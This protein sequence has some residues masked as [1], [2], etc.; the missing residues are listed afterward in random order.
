MRGEFVDLGGHRFYYFAAGTRGDG[1]PVVL[2]HGFPTSSRLWH[3]VIRDF[4]SGHRLVVCD[5]PGYGRS[6]PGPL[7]LGCGALADA[8]LKLLDDLR[9][10]RAAL[11]GHGLGGGVAQAVA[12]A[13]RDRVSH[14]ALIDSAA[15]GAAPRA[16]ARFARRALPLA[17][18]LPPGLLAGLVQGSAIRGFADPERSRLT[19]D[20]CLQ[21]FTT[22]MG[23]DVL[24]RHLR[25]LMQDE[26]ADL[27]PRLASLGIP[28]ALAWGRDDRFYPASLGQ[29]LA[30]AVPG[31]TLELIDGAGHFTPE[32][33][34]DRVRA[35]ITSL[36]AR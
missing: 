8:V 24:A 5:L 36:L 22:P 31:A 34:P 27:T 14:L 19:L 26:T 23:R 21:P 6:E 13:R 29:R 20:T 11:V 3:S 1:V 30:A 4:P 28:V 10:E 17:R 7:G 16:L 33:A 18:F 15:W 35:V 25:A 2:L 32:D 12:V 9:V